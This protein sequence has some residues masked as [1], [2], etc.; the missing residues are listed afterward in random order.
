M[1]FI[2]LRYSS[3]SDLESAELR[4]RLKGQ[5]HDGSG[6]AQNGQTSISPPGLPY[7]HPINILWRVTVMSAALWGLHA[8]SVFK[9][10]TRG[11]AVKHGW[12]KFGLAASVGENL[13]LK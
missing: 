2:H 13:I 1:P 4:Q 10:V 3:M 7:N 11:N 9:E 5:T 12:F 6:K 8:M